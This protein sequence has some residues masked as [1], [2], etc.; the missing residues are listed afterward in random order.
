MSGK[1]GERWSRLRQREDFAARPVKAIAK[2]LYYR[3]RS[4]VSDRPWTLALDGEFRVKVPI[5][6]TPGTAIFYLG[7][8]EPRT[9][10]LFKSLLRPGM[11]VADIGAHIGEYAL[12]ASRAVG[13][14]GRVFAFEPGEGVYPFLVENIASNGGANVTPFPLAVSD[15]E[16][17]L[18]FN[19][20]VDPGHSRLVVGEYGAAGLASKGMVP[21]RT[22][23]LERFEEQHGVAINLIKI[24][25]EGAEL[26]VLLGA[27]G[28]LSRP[29][30][31]APM[32]L[33]EYLPRTWN[34]Y[35]HSFDDGAD[36][37]AAHGYDLYGHGED[38]NLYPL[39]EATRQVMES[40]EL[41]LMIL[42]LKPEHKVAHRDAH[43]AAQL[44]RPDR[45]H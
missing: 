21:V 39:D 26:D 29:G 42:A 10:R 31:V 7:A 18:R 15:S 5:I 44:R 32:I 23:T 37:L 34:A 19:L 14:S 40:S 35:G 11:V 43:S 12:V 22:T 20:G 30:D 38:G 9:L 25:V 45:K 33:F 16:G 28:L 27:H 3:I 17:E 2:R 8:S 36:L 41:D 6:S 24:D 13:E 1:L 4:K